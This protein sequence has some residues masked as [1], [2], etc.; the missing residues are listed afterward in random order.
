MYTFLTPYSKPPSLP[1]TIEGQNHI[2]VVWAPSVIDPAAAAAGVNDRPG[3][4]MLAG[5]LGL[6]C[7]RTQSRRE[8]A[9]LGG[10]SVAY[11]GMVR[12]CTVFV[13]HAN[14]KGKIYC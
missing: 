11:M 5:S 1:D 12:V 13:E 6:D 4:D 3:T 14:T 10:T 7:W 9:G 2:T 8:N